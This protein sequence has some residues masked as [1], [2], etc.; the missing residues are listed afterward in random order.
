M[1]QTKRQYVLIGF[2]EET[3]SRVFAFDGV[4]G[5]RSRSVFTVRADLAT[6]RR[7]GI[8]L[9][10]LPLLCREI[11]E[12]CDHSETRRSFTF[13]EG[14]M[15]QLADDRTAARDAAALKRRPPRRPVGENAGAG[16]RA[17]PR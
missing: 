5:D 17:A 3:G 6:S 14:D 11:L 12:R 9:Q 7:Y 15:R 8:R 10:E 13:T 16:W 4:A 1:D 2:R